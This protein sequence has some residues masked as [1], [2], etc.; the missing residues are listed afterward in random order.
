MNLKK[1]SVYIAS[2]LILSM[3]LISMF[4]GIMLIAPLS[5]TNI[6]AKLPSNISS[7]NS[8]TSPYVTLSNY[9]SNFVVNGSTYTISK[10]SLNVV[11]GVWYQDGNITIENGGTLILNGVTMLFMSDNGNPYSSSSPVHHL[12]INITNNAKLIL[13]NSTISTFLYRINPFERLHMY[14]QQNSMV[15]ANNNSKFLFPG[16]INVSSGSSLYLN[17]SIVSSNPEIYNLYQQTKNKQMYLSDAWAP[18][19]FTNKAHVFIYNSSLGP[20][21]KDP[22][23]TPFNATFGQV[24][25]VGG[26]SVRG[27]PLTAASTSYTVSPFKS[28][29]N[30]TYIFNYSTLYLLFGAT[31]SNTQYTT[32]IPTI[33]VS[34]TVT[35]NNV[36]YTTT[37][38]FSLL[39]NV[40]I[41][42]AYNLMP[43]TNLPSWYYNYVSYSNIS[44]SAT[45]SV[46][47]TNPS[48]SQNVF[49]YSPMTTFAFP[50]DGYY[51]YTFTGNSNVTVISS[52]ID[53]NWY[54]ITN[55]YG[56]YPIWLN[57]SKASDNFPNKIN[58]YDSSRGFFMN[59]TVTG[60]ISP[61]SATYL[62]NG[63]S[64]IQTYGSSSAVIYSL[65]KLFVHDQTNTPVG[66]AILNITSYPYPFSNTP[67]NPLI[68]NYY[69]YLKIVDPLLYN[70][71][72]TTYHPYTSKVFNST[73]VK[74]TYAKNQYVTPY[75]P[76]T[77]TKGYVIF[78]L[79][80]NVISSGTLEN[81]MYTGSYNISVLAN[82]TLTING[83][84]QNKNFTGY[85]PI[86]FAPYPTL[87]NSTNVEFANA[88]MVIWHPDFMIV[89]PITITNTQ[90]IY[91][92]Q[93]IHVGTVTIK[94]YGVVYPT[95]NVTVFINL[96]NPSGVVTN[97]SMTII[98][99]TNFLSNSE[100][101]ITGV[102]FTLGRFGF[103]GT[104]K[105]TVHIVPTGLNTTLNKTMSTN[106]TVNGL[107]TLS[108]TPVVITF[109]GQQQL[110]NSK[111]PM[112]SVISLNTT[113]I[114][115]IDGP[116]TNV[117]VQYM[118][119]F[120][121]SAFS[122]IGSQTIP[123][124]P[125]NGQY[126]LQPLQFTL[127]N[128]GTYNFTVEIA[129]WGQPNSHVIE[130]TTIVQIY[131]VMLL[132]IKNINSYGFTQLNSVHIGQYLQI[133]ITL[134]N[135]GSIQMNNVNLSV[136][137][138]NNVLIYSNNA[139]SIPAQQTIT[140]NIKWKVNETQ[141]GSTPSTHTIL[142]VAK[143]SNEQVSKTFTITILPSK[144]SV[145]LN[146]IL[147]N[148]FT[149]YPN[150]LVTLNVSVNYNGT[151][152]AS[153]IVTLYNGTTPVYTYTNNT[154]KVG[155]N[156]IKFNVP[157]IPGSY[158]V[159]IT[160]EYNGVKAYYVSSNNYVLTVMPPVSTQTASTS[161]SSK[162]SFPLL[163]LIIIII[164]VVVVV[165][166]VVFLFVL[167]KFMKAEYSECGECGAIIPAN[168]RKC[169]KC[170]VE[171]EYDTVKC[172][173][174]GA[175]MPA[176][177]KVCNE[178]GAL[179]TG[180]KL[181]PN[182]PQ[183]IMRK[184]YLNYIQKYKDMAKKEMGKDYS[185]L[186]FWKWWKSKPSY[187]TYSKWAEQQGS[188]I[189]TSTTGPT[190][191]LF[192]QAAQ[193]AVNA[194]PPT[195]PTKPSQPLQ[196]P[197]AQAPDLK[198]P[199]NPAQ[200]AGYA[201]PGTTPI[202]STKKVEEVAA[203]PAPEEVKKLLE[204]KGGPYQGTSKPTGKTQKCPNCSR[205]L[206]ED[207]T[208]CPYC[209]F[210]VK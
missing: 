175:W 57:P 128:N 35:V 31:Y 163:D 101:N 53:A 10:T 97:S 67:A 73:F 69:N 21:F 194:S 66:K 5:S 58:M 165:A 52:H 139:I 180:Q 140:E 157:A 91:E 105:I 61:S 187:I 186:N 161:S 47:W 200:T 45:V 141:V 123:S 196:Q 117:V 126:Q 132:G 15:I 56:N 145:K 119:S 176:N 43:I 38:S 129:S 65:I 23:P 90:P 18:S 115:G 3:L 62:F 99:Y 71:V 154:I 199:V 36:K 70:Y 81:G 155:Y 122:S 95:H 80:S 102:S 148:M 185:E 83:K 135:N 68:S 24:E 87:S 8:Y 98:S 142:S 160:A 179:F 150:N 201:I 158:K 86:S 178:C 197:L 131:A 41:P 189:P 207:I 124:I 111:I 127:S 11:N 30:S 103:V 107:P 46:T 170:G 64:A 1:K 169:P 184:E 20:T 110:N 203:K 172:S 16:T 109:K 51:N 162:S 206:P 7:K 192:A 26:V 100:Y 88:S 34:F 147:S 116:A 39:P 93:T 137:L 14:V 108:I 28:P 85:L 77:N 42:A 195:Q 40:T 60:Q 193:N 82:T 17:N 74:T 72:N 59:L 75:S 138:D 209:G 96:T 133:N 210:I 114:N 32:N 168:A 173:E 183:E 177:S 84:L 104:N 19:I 78:P 54:P 174:C 106:F 63:T 190:T 149:I 152:D 125:T 27:V 188:K 9:T 205:E 79:V 25:T 12:W 156:L 134:V 6:N 171:F 29:L 4:A 143:W 2:L 182:S 118:M 37:Q 121:G 120:N 13:N 130:S 204:T 112:G 167:P 49:L 151:K 44:S 50:Y 153:L 181:E 94:R 164:V 48:T 92:T 76:I 202:T 159:N 166:L 55:V 33:S 191:N 144:V 22:L 136:Y 198:K 208:V 146:T 89:P 113:V